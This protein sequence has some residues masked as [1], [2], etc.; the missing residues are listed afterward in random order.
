VPSALQ[1]IAE[2]LAQIERLFARLGLRWFLFGA[3]AAILH[4]VARL[5]AD[6]DVTIDLGDRSTRELIDAL[7][8]AG[9]DPRVASVEDFV[10]RTRVLP[11]VHR[12]SHIPVDLVLAGPGLEEQFFAG[13]ERRRIG[14]ALVPVASA[15]D[16][17]A[18]KILAGRPRDL[19]DVAAIVHARG[20]GLDLRRV[21]GTLG[22]L[23]KA[24][25]RRDLV[26]ELER[27]LAARTATGEDRPR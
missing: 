9:F 4:G 5:S 22:L 27:V 16:L 20:A 8:G 18:M 24:L 11:V 25:D 23:E 3:Q 6:V 26:G 7:A 12:A 10:E 14:D 15:E 1:P 2:L 13:A 21:R 17:I 19:E